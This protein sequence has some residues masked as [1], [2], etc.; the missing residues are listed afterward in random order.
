[1]NKSLPFPTEAGKES[2]S[3]YSSGNASKQQ[4]TR[5]ITIGSSEISFQNL[6]SPEIIILW[7]YIS[8]P[9]CKLGMLKN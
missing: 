9:S 3:K 7:V 2:D 5:Q 6:Y 1:M 8:P 4:Q